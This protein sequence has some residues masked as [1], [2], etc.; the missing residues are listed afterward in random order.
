MTMSVSEEDFPIQFF[1]IQPVAGMVR[2]LDQSV[3]KRFFSKHQAAPN[4]LTVVSAPS[5][6]KDSP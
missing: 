4:P 3:L 5:T 6:K 1:G 2:E